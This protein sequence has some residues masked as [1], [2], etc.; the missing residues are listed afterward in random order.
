MKI[1]V[2]G[3]G[4]MGLGAAY[5]LAH[6]SPDVTAVTV[7]DLDGERARAVCETVDSPKLTPAQVDVEDDA[8]V[9]ALM[10]GHDAAL[11]CVTYFHNLRLARA[12]IEAR[13][14]FCD[15]GGNN[16][17]VDAELALDSEARAAGVNVIP[18][19]GLAPGM[20]AV[21]A[22]HGA[23]RFDEIEAIHI[24]VGGLPL[25]PKPPLNYQI[26]FSVEGLIN[27]YVERARVVRGGRIVE[28]ESMTE[29]EELEF[30][31]PFGRMEAF[32][33]SGGTSTLPDTFAGRIRELDYKTI[34]YPGHC[35]QVKLL[36]DLGLASSDE[37]DLNGVRVA[38]RRLLGEMLLRHLPADEPDAVLVRLEFRGSQGGARRTLRYDI[39][40]RFDERTRLSAM[41]RTTAFPAS[42]VAQ[43]MA[44][45]A[46]MKKGALPQELS[47][48]PAP[49]VAA[50]AAR[51]IRIEENFID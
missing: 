47:I 13:T 8:R 51:D 2:L 38:P 10:R 5:D 31:A 40:D 46:T 27:E 18:D 11:S 41:M 39:I 21:L 26:V 17:V 50:L 29:I 24:R 9:V 15:L 25:Q 22:A 12:A 28:V 20:V 37:V 34:R 1:L 45:G 44:R 6:N 35:A 32:Q 14:N 43:T 48:P 4:R 3:A 7:A 16:S 36:I 42:I 33:T 49:F 19:C 23:E 30:P